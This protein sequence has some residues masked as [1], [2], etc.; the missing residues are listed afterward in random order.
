VRRASIQHS[1]AFRK[2]SILSVFLCLT[3]RP[4]PWTRRLPLAAIPVPPR[5][6]PRAGSPLLLLL[7]LAAGFRALPRST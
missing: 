3:L 1:V 6:L 2:H 7:L 5:R 4:P